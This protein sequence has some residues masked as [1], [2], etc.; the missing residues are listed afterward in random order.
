[1]RLIVSI[2]SFSPCATARGP[3][4]YLAPRIPN[5][6]SN[7]PSL[8][9]VCGPASFR[10]AAGLIEPSAGI[11]SSGRITLPDRPL[12]ASGQA[13]RPRTA[14]QIAGLEC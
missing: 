6:N 5:N 14:L 13:T 4:A 9:A 8:L 11:N 12:S 3:R 2:L 10:P 7:Y 1:M